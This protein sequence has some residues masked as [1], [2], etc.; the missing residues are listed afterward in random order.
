MRQKARS[1]VVFL[2]S[3][4][5]IFGAIGG[6]ADAARAAEPADAPAS[7]P[8]KREEPAANKSGYLQLFATAMGGTGLRFDNPY[9]LPTPL[10]SDAQSVSR[11]AA[12]LDLGFATTFGNPLGLQHG[13]SLRSSTAVEGVGQ[14]VLTPAYFAWRRWG[15]L[16]AYGRAGVPI[17]LTPSVTWGLEAA[18]GGAFFFLGGLGVVGEIVGD[19]IYGEG[20]R[21]RAVSTYP[22]LSAQLGLIATYEVLP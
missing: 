19:V 14:E 20:T 18:G 12:Y 2:A 6:A 11:T 15:R 21:D 5:A 13:I 10:G 8:A 9:R 17:L 16:A 3:S 22:I 4:L 1:S 7:P